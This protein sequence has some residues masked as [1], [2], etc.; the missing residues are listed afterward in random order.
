MSADDGGEVGRPA[1]PDDMV[2][3]WP[4]LPRERL[5][6]LFADLAEQGFE[7][8]VVPADADAPAS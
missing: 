8:R 5:E 3:F 4:D 7:M 2:A 1:T 6:T